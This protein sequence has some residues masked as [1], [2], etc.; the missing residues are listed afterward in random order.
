M[1]KNKELKVL[2]ITG[3]FPSV[4]CGIGDYTCFV[5][6]EMAVQG[7]DVSVLTSSYLGIKAQHRIINVMPAVTGWGAMNSGR[8]L[9]EIRKADP[10]IVHMQYPNLEYKKNLSTNLLPFMIKQKLP[11]IKIIETFHEP[12]KDLGL[13]GKMRFMLNFPFADGMIFVEKEN[14]LTLPF[15]LKFSVRRTKKAFIPIASNIPRVKADKKTRSTI[16]KR[17]HLNKDKKILMTF[18]FITGVKGYEQI[19]GIIDKTEYEWVHIGKIDETD[20]YQR[21]FRE[22]A[23][24]KRMEIKFSGFLPADET[25]KYLASSDVCV[26][27]FVEG[28]T[29]RHGTFLAAA[30]QGVYIA[31]Y[32]KSKRGYVKRENVYYAAPGDL[33]GLKKGIELKRHA[34][35]VIP[36]IPTWKQVAEKHLN[37]YRE[38]LE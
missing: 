23:E 33:E 32:H 21:G 2:M 15:Y 4:K 38:I 37:F 16:V 17:L 1:L 20:S 26:F 31:A 9:A 11:H 25:A 3:S 24:K 12:I 28:V 19:F 36:D 13:M 8:I 18:G 30:N 35:T 14:W 27:P 22:K 6:N 10:D 5:C 34:K 7:A 29:D